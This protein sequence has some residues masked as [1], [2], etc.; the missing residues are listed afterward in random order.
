MC[1][2]IYIY[3]YIHTYICNCCGSSVR[4]VLEDMRKSWIIDIYNMYYIYIYIHTYIHTYI[5][6]YIYIHTY[7]MLMLY[8]WHQIVITWP[9]EL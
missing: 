3:I 7:I 6:I 9:V 2:Y 1:V 4:S 5:Y 8:M